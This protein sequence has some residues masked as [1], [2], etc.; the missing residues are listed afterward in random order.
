M[1]EMSSNIILVILVTSF[2]TYLSRFLG[3]VSSEKIDAK[4]KIFRW[5][6]CIAYSILAALIARIVIFPAGVL[7]E[8]DLWIRLIVIIISI[9]I[10]IISKRNLVYPTVLSAIVLAL[11][12]NYL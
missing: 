6:N 12:N 2:A 7:E 1:S 9:I 8:V 4:S 5:F 11:L 10:F 3:V